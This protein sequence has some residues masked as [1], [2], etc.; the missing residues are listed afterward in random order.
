MVAVAGRPHLLDSVSQPCTVLIAAATLLPALRQRAATPGLEVIAFADT[1][2]LQAVETIVRRRPSTVSLELA[3]AASPRGAALIN[4]L[5]AD[6]A[7]SSVSVLVVTAGDTGIVATPA[8]HGPSPL[9][10]LAD[11]PTQ[12]AMR[13]DE[14]GTRGAPRVT[15]AKG[16]EAL[17]DGNAVVLVDLS[18]G[19]AQVLSPGVLKPS[20]RVRITLNDEHGTLKLTGTIAWATFEIPPRYRAGI[21]F[22]GGD[23][24]AIELYALRH[25]A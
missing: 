1:D 16:V 13:L 11:Q 17:V 9:A 21:E 5:K 14:R 19:G 7:L 24:A 23:S 20:Q 18:A 2:A 22:I 25:Q 8:P 4:R 3:F 6:P 12:V 10:A 15:M